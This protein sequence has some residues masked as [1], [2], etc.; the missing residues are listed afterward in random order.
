MLIDYILVFKVLF[1]VLDKALDP[2]TV[3]F[4]G[5]RPGS[6]YIPLLYFIRNKWLILISNSNIMHNYIDCTV[7]NGV[8]LICV[9]FHAPVSKDGEK[10]VYSHYS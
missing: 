5:A 10:S 7:L 9:Q 1:V 4:M 8:I 3:L 2:Y 6:Y